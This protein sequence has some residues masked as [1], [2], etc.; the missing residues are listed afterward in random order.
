M[1]ENLFDETL[2]AMPDSAARSEVEPIETIC[3]IP[4]RNDLDAAAALILAYLLLST[5]A[6]RTQKV[7]FV[8]RPLSG[9]VYPATFERAGLVCLSVIS[10]TAPARA[11][12]LVHR[13]RR[14]AP[15]ANVLI[16]LWGLPSAE[17]AEATTALGNSAGIVTNLHDAVAAVPAFADGLP[18]APASPAVSRVALGN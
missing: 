13:V 8:D 12:Y 6:A 17:L 4:G 10:T 2:D 18:T 14:R 9:S 7:V 11:R 5:E 15:G 3:C 1:L 16:G